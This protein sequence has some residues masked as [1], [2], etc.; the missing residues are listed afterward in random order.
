MRPRHV[1][2]GALGAILFVT[3]CSGDEDAAPASTAP[4]TTTTLVAPREEDGQLRLGVL[5]P[6]T[7][8]LLGGP[9]LEAVRSAV[10]EINE[11][12]GVLDRP[13][14][15][16]VADEATWGHGFA[17]RYTCRGHTDRLA[18][19]VAYADTGGSDR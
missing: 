1:L 5:L 8:T 10:D 19:G 7:D 17:N 4:A 18:D 15:T 13:V 6:S 11:S 12:G 16:V 9:L 3:A 14:S 2:V